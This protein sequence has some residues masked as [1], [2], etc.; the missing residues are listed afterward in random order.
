MGDMSIPITS[1]VNNADE[2]HD[3]SAEGSPT[4]LLSNPMLEEINQKQHL[5][6]DKSKKKANIGTD[7]K[8]SM[9]FSENTG[10]NIDL[11]IGPAPL[12][13]EEKAIKERENCDYSIKIT[14]DMARTSTAPRKIRIYADGRYISHV[15]QDIFY[16]EFQVFTIYFTRVM[17]DN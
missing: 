7:D 12:C 6:N 4:N 15:I 13:Y 5:F 1:G 2:W 3:A 10:V 9:Q 14:L 8:R 16:G 17:L 11:N